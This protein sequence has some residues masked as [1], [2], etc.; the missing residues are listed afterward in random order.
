MAKGMPSRRRQIW[1]A[2]DR[3]ASDPGPPPPASRQRSWNSEQRV[4][5]AVGRRRIPRRQRQRRH[6][7]HDLTADVQRDP[8]RREQRDTRA[9]HEHG[10]GERRDGVDDVLGVVEDEE[11]ASVAEVLDEPLDVASVVV[12]VDDEPDD[13]RDGGDHP[14]A[15]GQRGQLDEPHAVAVAFERRGRRL[16]AEA[17]L[18]HAPDAGE[19]HEA[20]CRQQRRDVR[21]LRGP[22]DEPR[23]RQR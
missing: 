4:A 13:A 7:A 23:Q 18:A 17:G 1:T 22:A 14:A 21:Q 5:V 2:A 10:V 8:A 6:G 20:V 12:P 11:H 9:A 3:S 16:E 19:R 15:V